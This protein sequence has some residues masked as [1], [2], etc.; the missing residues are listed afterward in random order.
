MESSFLLDY[1]RSSEA[2]GSSL[3][4]WGLNRVWC[5]LKGFTCEA[6]TVCLCVQKWGFWG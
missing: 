5:V 3:G 1:V 2:D 4:C 6:V